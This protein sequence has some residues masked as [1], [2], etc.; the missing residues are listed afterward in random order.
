MT[1]KLAKKIQTIVSDLKSQPVSNQF[2]KRATE[3]QLTRDENPQTH[4]CVYFA[5][6]DPKA[7]RV[8]LGN[9]KKSGLWLFNGGHIDEGETPNEALAREISE[10]WG[11]KTFKPKQKLLEEE[12]SQTSWL[13]ISEARK[14]VSDPNTLVGLTEFEKV[15]KKQ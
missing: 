8:F 5:A 15:F 1:S 14:L 13:T 2:R 7:K 12:F 4:F 3:G 6:C 9:H 11:I 10:E